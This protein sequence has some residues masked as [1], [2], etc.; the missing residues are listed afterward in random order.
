MPLPP[1][2]QGQPKVPA[3]SRKRDSLKELLARAKAK[4]YQRGAH[5]EEDG[6]R[7]HHKYIDKIKKDQDVALD[8]YVL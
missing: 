7:K 4:E 3:T 5:K 2:P 6:V 1:F 8:L